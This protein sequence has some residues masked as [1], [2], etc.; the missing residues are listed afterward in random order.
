MDEVHEMR[1][2]SQLERILSQEGERALCYAWL[3]TQSQKQYAGWNTYLT[4]PS[5]V[6]STIAGTASIGSRTLFGDGEIPPV[7][8]GFFSLSVGVLNT[9]N[10]YFGWG[11]RSEAHKIA[12]VTYSKIHRFIMIELALPRVER[13]A[14]HDM[15]KVV[16]EQL[17]RLQE[18]SPQ[19][20]DR[21]I[22]KFRTAFKDNNE[23]TKPEITNGL[24]PIVVYVDGMSSLTSR[25][26]ISG[27]TQDKSQKSSLV[28]QQSGFV[29]DNNHTSPSSYNQNTTSQSTQ[30]HSS[31]TTSSPSQ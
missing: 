9:V 30:P 11:K 27:H 4:L 10:S 2:N 25:I 12:G 23:V 5:I 29:T 28:R 21:V 14:A 17:D 8:I 18:T 20:P 26:S 31:N 3:H 22:M 7:V 1:W 19:I 24:D 6:V 13:M 16:R 15:L